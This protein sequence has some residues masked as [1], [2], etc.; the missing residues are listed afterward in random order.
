MENPDSPSPLTTKQQKAAYMRRYYDT[1]PEAKERMLA[2]KAE[3][4]AARRKELAA[5]QLAR[6][7]ASHDTELERRKL[8]RQTQEYKDYQLQYQREW[9]QKNPDKVRTAVRKFQSSEKGRH[10]LADQKGK[11]RAR[12]RN[13][14]I[15]KIDWPTV[16]STFNGT[17]PICT[18]PLHLGV[19]KF[20]FDHIVALGRGGS[21]STDNLQV[22]HASCNLRKNRY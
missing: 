16:W 9:R 3:Y 17:C 1:R 21:H 10:S 14:A 22:A 13:N 15:G 5:A 20:H 11:R 12:E 19:E 6:Y 4:R 7:Y 2:K 18:K 8:L